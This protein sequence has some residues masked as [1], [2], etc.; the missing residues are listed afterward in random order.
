MDRIK[1]LLNGFGYADL[2]DLYNST[3]RLHC[4]PNFSLWA[5]VCTIAGIIL[6]VTGLE[7]PALLSLVVLLVAEFY[8]GVKVSIV[9]RGERFKSRKCGRMIL[10]ICIYV[11]ILSVLNI[12]SNTI[13]APDFIGVSINPFRWLYYSVLTAIIFQLVVSWMENLGALGY[14]ETK[15][16]AGFVLRKLNK[17][18]EFDGTKNNGPE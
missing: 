14:R 2:T 13:H 8:T 7:A 9:K 3:F 5:C 11:L 15:T 16:I 10:K 18:F 12:F 6:D 17:W 1:Y 4:A